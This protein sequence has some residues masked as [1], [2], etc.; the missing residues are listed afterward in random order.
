MSLKAR[1]TVVS[2]CLKAEGGVPKHAQP[3]VTVGP[4]GL[5]GDFHAGE[6]C[7]HG[8]RAGQAN[9]RQVSVVAREAVAEAAAQLSIEVPPGGL[10]ENILV[11]GLGDLSSLRPGQRLRFSSGA[12]L[13]VTAQNNPCKNLMVWHRKL[14]KQLAGRRGVVCTV[15]AP[16][17]L[18]PGDSVEIDG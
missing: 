11:S 5:E 2:V 16:G 13:R 4:Y 9:D 6:V 7:R 15:L 10:A 12:E 8:S 18:R 3:E 17:P 14:P 1:G